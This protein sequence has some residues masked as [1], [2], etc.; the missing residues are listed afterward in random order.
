MPAKELYQD[1]VVNAL[2]ADGRTITHCE[3]AMAIRNYRL[4]WAQSQI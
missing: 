2:V 4:I 1:A 3:L